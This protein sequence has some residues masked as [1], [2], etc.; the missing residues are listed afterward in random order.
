MPPPGALTL[1]IWLLD[2]QALGK[3]ASEVH[4]WNHFWV[5]IEKWIWSL[6][7]LTLG[8]SQVA[9][10]HLDYMNLLCMANQT[11]H[12]STQLLCIMLVAIDLGSS[13]KIVAQEAEPTLVV[14]MVAIIGSSP[15]LWPGPNQ[16]LCF[17]W[18][19]LGRSPKLWP[20]PTPIR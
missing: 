10:G 2:N 4:A 13:P 9:L 16:L 8:V 20:T 12:L 19:P 7:Y 11:R 3:L 6:H 1:H 15:K 5:E 18:W 17:A 14:H